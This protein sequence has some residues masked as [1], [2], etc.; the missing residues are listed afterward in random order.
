[1]GSFFNIFPEQDKMLA[2][3]TSLFWGS[4]GTDQSK[5]VEEDIHVDVP[6]SVED[7]DSFISPSQ[8]QITDVTVISDDENDW[9]LVNR[10]APTPDLS[11]SASPVRS[12]HH[13]AELLEERDEQQQQQPLAIAGAEGNTRAAGVAQRTAE[14]LQVIDVLRPAQKAQ[15]RREERRLKGKQLDR[16]NKAREVDSSCNKRSKRRNML[17]PC[18]FS[19]AINNR[20][21]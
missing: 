6:K 8:P 4:E 1:M 13:D 14:L 15:R 17:T 16:S 7:S 12:V 3:L 2:N 18:K 21:C 5:T 10:K 11:Q 19:R 20:K 9:V